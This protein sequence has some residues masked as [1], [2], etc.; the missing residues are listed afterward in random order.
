MTETFTIR[1]Q[2][3]FTTQVLGEL[4]CGTENP[5]RVK[6]KIEVECTGK[7][8]DDRGFL[9][10]Q[11]KIAE[12]FSEVHATHDSCE[13]LARYTGQKVYYRI[14]KENPGCQVLRF[15]LSLSPS[16]FMAELEYR[17]DNL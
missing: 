4:H 13:K 8:L 14:R 17:M 15:T 11:A 3:E 1:R 9:F 12:V 5:L 16:P 2:G 7:S 6:F 10:D